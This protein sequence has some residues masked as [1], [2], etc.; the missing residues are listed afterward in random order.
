MND[1]Y[2]AILNEEA[3]YQQKHLLGRCKLEPSWEETYSWNRNIA[4]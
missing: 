2:V 3:Y 4:K 1:K